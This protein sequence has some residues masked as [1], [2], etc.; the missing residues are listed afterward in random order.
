MCVLCG[1]GRCAYVCVRAQTTMERS[2]WGECAMRMDSR[3]TLRDKKLLSKNCANAEVFHPLVKRDIYMCVC[4]EGTVR[5]TGRCR[6]DSGDKKPKAIGVV[7]QYETDTR[8]L[9]LQKRKNK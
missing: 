3:K 8:E 1:G 5:Q 4:N 2:G 9:I 6:V 7:D